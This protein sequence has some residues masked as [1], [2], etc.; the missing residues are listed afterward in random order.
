MIG[1]PNGFWFAFLFQ[2]S[3]T[4][5]FES[6][7]WAHL[8]LFA[9]V[10]R[11]ESRATR[12]RNRHD[13]YAETRLLRAG[14]TRPPVGQDAWRDKIRKAEARAAELEKEGSLGMKGEVSDR[15][16]RLDRL[17][18]A[19]RVGQGSVSCPG[20]GGIWRDLEGLLEVRLMLGSCSAHARLA[21]PKRIGRIRQKFRAFGMPNFP[22]ESISKAPS[23]GVAKK[24]SQGHGPL[25]K[26]S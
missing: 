24:T 11:S 12:V 22:T 2:G 17:V 4:E 23:G 14:E 20:M 26:L 19:R 13:A 6:T 1:L 18:G 3:R 5:R 15:L 8:D 7:P 10:T 25:F 9:G 16:I 21:V